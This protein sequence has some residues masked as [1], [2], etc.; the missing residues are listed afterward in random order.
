MKYCLYSV[1]CTLYSSISIARGSKRTA[2]L[3]LFIDIRKYFCKK[4]EICLHIFTFWRNIWCF[5]LR[6]A[7]SHSCLSFHFR[8][9]F[10]P[11]VR[12]RLAAHMPFLHFCSSTPPVA[13]IIHSLRPRISV[14]TLSEAY[15]GEGV[16][17]N[18][19]SMGRVT[20][21]GIYAIRMVIGCE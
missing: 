6:H 4:N 11:K 10:P 19:S 1:F 14:Y 2:K 21:K 12:S 18:T 13:L 5:V 8:C 15:F 17:Q 7:P 20:P 9:G 3:L 16:R